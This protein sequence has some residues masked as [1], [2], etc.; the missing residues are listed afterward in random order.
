LKF[1]F[2]AF[3]CFV[4]LESIGGT[5]RYAKTHNAFIFSLTNS[6]SLVPFV[7]KVKPTWTTYAIHRH[8]FYGPKFGQDLKISL[9]NAGRIQNS[10]ARLEAAYAVPAA[11]QVLA[12]T[13]LFVPDEVEVF[14]LD[15]PR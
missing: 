12:G 15:P 8:S 7:S 11:K 10:K 1:L 6:G 5:G 2:Y 13:E 3:L 14:Y 4:L 9:R